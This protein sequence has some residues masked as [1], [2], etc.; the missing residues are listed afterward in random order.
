MSSLGSGNARHTGAHSLTPV[1]S[2]SRLSRVVYRV[3]SHRSVPL[4]H[5]SP[6][7]MPESFVVAYHHR[8]ILFHANKKGQ[9][10]GLSAENPSEH[11]EA[12]F[13]ELFENHLPRGLH[14]VSL[15]SIQN[16]WLGPMA[17]V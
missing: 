3:F 6:E 8:E 1:A 17:I 12:V 10:S 9:T 4:H 7:I 5:C 15:C 2:F 14:Q 11:G 16:V 13:L